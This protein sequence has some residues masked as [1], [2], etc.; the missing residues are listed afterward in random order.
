[1]V[2]K[3]MAEQESTSGDGEGSIGGGSTPVRTIDRDTMRLALNI[4][5]SVGFGLQLLWPGQSLPEGTD[6]RLHKYTTL[7]PAAGH[8]MSFVD[9][10]AGMLDTLLLLLIV[11]EWL[12]RRFHPPLSLVSNPALRESK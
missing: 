10:V 9:A 5:A 6:P 1:M 3:W 7:E 11:P 4:I 2:E 8:T 12:L